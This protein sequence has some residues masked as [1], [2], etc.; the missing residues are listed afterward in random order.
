MVLTILNELMTF[1]GDKI[2][3]PTKFG[4]RIGILDFSVDLAVIA[5][6]HDNSVGKTKPKTPSRQEKLPYS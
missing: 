1:Y 4:F 2:K 5:W 3:V 6:L